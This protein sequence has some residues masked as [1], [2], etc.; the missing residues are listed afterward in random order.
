VVG[1]IPDVLLD[2]TDR[3]RTSPF[4]FTGNKFEFRAVGSNANCSNAMTTLNAIVA[5]QLKDFKIEVDTLIDSKDMKKDD[6][7]FNVLREYIKQSK[8]ILFEGD[9]YSEAWEK[10]AA[11][12]GLSNFKTTPEAIKAKVSKQ[13]LDLFDEMG[14]LNHVEA[15]A[16]YE[17]ELEEYTKKI[18]IEGRVLGDI[19]R[20]HVIP[21]AIRYQNTLIE[22]VKGLKEI[23][24]KE[25]ETIAKEQILLIKEISGHIEGI[26]SK[27]AAMTNERRTAN[28]LTDAQ[29]MAEAYCNKVIPYFENIRN[30][31]DKLELLVDDESWTLTKYRELLLT[32]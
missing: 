31:C 8:K 25:F 6:A 19:S 26:S 32:K 24:G 21:T 22:N 4:A 10:E 11:K 2:N 9:G 14:I 30:H 20:N 23:F 27:V 16:R 17:I 29:K 5:K 13:A 12:R 1:K 3:N 28:S 15:E 7:I 18:Q